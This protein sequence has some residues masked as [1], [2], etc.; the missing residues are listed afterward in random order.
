E[1]DP[2][3]RPR[4][5]GRDRAVGRTGDRRRGSCGHDQRDQ[6]ECDPHETSHRVAR[7]T[8]VDA[9]CLGNLARMAHHPMSDD[10]VRAFL[11]ADPARPAILATTRAD[12]RPHVAPI[13]YVVSPVK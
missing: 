13:W 3:D 12:G 1:P 2:L 5:R 7:R 11:T 9:R 4:A 10:E 8:T 6:H